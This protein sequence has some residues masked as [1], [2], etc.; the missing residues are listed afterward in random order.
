MGKR[1]LILGAVIGAI[2]IVLIV[3]GVMSRPGAD[4]T[5][6]KQEIA[7]DFLADYFRWDVSR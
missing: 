2:A 1:K 7:A 5:E 3:L 4:S 6:K